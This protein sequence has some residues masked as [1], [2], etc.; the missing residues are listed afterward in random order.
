MQ[1]SR[2]EINYWDEGQNNAKYSSYTQ[3]SKDH[4]QNLYVAVDYI[5]DINI[6]KYTESYNDKIRR[7]SKLFLGRR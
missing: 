4:Q 1:Q 3:C 2:T 6:F 5:I 7:R